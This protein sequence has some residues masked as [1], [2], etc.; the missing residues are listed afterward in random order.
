MK[1]FSLRLPADLH[2]S[3]TELAQAE[4]RSLH[5]QIL[6]MLEDCLGS[7]QLRVSEMLP[8]GPAP[9]ASTEVVGGDET[10]MIMDGD[11]NQPVDLLQL[12]PQTFAVFGRRNRHFLRVLSWDPA[13]EDSRREFSALARAGYHVRRWG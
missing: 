10:L 5:S 9:Q 12:K 3:L 8:G 13:S 2:Q 6:I 11:R 4:H 1:R 7:H